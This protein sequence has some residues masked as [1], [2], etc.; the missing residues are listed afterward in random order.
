MSFSVFVQKPKDLHA[1]LQKVKEEAINNNVS[2][3]GDISGGRA[4]GFGFDASYAVHPT[5]VEIIVHKKPLL[6]TESFVRG[7]ITE[8]CAMHHF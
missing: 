8:C 7:K 1:A 6:M 4:S 5:N 3:S 2:F